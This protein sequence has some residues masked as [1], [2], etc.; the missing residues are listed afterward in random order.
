MINISG[1]GLGAQ[2]TASNTFPNGFNVTEWADDAD[3]L[4]SPDLEL[5]DTGMGL[6]GDMVVWSRPMGIEISLN[7]IPTTESDT[8]LDV[9]AQANRVARG[10]R[11]ARDTIGIVFTYPNGQIVTMSSGVMISGPMAPPVASA[12]RMK[13][14]MYK[15]RFE[16]I[17]K[18]N[19]P[20]P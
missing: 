13:T 8:N 11:G 1:F 16:Q 5:A 4:D 7:V 17:S 12:G 20:Q 3:P 14:H 6:N 2:V 15:F 9:L 19:A 10:K 18:S